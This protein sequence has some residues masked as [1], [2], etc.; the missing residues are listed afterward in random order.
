MLSLCGQ[1]ASVLERTVLSLSRLYFRYTYLRDFSYIAAKQIYYFEIL[2]NFHG[3]ES[4]CL[5]VCSFLNVLL[6]LTYLPFSHKIDTNLKFKFMNVLFLGAFLGYFS[7]TGFFMGTPTNMRILF[8]RPKQKKDK[9]PEVCRGA[10]KTPCI[11]DNWILI[12]LN[13]MKNTWSKIKQFTTLN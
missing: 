8:L 9:I 12:L 6:Y 1:S 2:W 5:Q 13:L 7:Y 3:L 10:H 4:N 11:A